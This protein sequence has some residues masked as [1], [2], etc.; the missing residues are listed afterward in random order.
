M[1][2][3]LERAA[4]LPAQPATHVASPPLSVG[5]CARPSLRCTPLEQH[6]RTRHTSYIYNNRQAMTYV[7]YMHIAFQPLVVNNYFWAGHRQRSPELT[8][9]ILVR[10]GQ[11]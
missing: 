3:L 11:N 10:L 4:G 9:F 2:R 1:A 6:G 5:V 7:A 8:R